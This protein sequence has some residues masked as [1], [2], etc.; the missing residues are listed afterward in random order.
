MSIKLDLL[1]IEWVTF[2]FLSTSIFHHGRQRIDSGCFGCKL[3]L[4]CESTK[5]KSL[6]SSQPYNVVKYIS[7]VPYIQLEGIEY[8]EI[9]RDAY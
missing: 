4:V 7:Y 5:K 6:V 1:R 3:T 8:E 9:H 2:I